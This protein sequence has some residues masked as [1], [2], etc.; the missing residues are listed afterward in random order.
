MVE[1]GNKYGLPDEDVIERLEMHN[2]KIYQTMEVGDIK[3][4]I[5][6]GKYK[7]DLTYTHEEKE[8]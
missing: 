7:F 2:A 3:L 1:K 4:V 8:E 5:D 6:D